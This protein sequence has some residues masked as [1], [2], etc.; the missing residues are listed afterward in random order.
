MPRIPS[1]RIENEHFSYFNANPKN[2]KTV[3]DCVF[4]AISSALDKSWD[5]VFVGLSEIG[6]RLKAP[7][8]DK[9]TF[10]EYLK[11]QGW[12]KMPQPK[13]SDNTKYKA[14]DFARLNNKNTYVISLAHHLSCIKDGKIIDTWDCGDYTVGNY[15]VKK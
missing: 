7:A 2:K 15:W 3:G 5:D 4:R 10:D 12:V 6:L 9:I 1:Y 11:S 8:N 13:K 14:K